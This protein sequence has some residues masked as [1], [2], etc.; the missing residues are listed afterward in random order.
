MIYN[1]EE[2]NVTS[3]LLDNEYKKLDNKN[4]LII[5]GFGFI[6]KYLLNTLIFIRDNL[7]IKINI[8][9]LDNFITSNKEQIEYFSKFNIK[10]IEHDIL[11]KFKSN[12]VFDYVAF[13]AGIAS[14]YYYNKFPMETLELSVIGLKNSFEINH[15]ENTKYIFF[16]SSEIYGDPDDKN[17][18]TKE[19][20]RGNVSTVGPRSCYDESK[21]L[22]ETICYIKSTK[23][24]FKTAIIRPFNVYGPG[25]LEDD[26]RIIPN[27][28]KCI[29]NNQSLDIYDTGI[30]T[31]TYCYIADAINGFIRVFLNEKNFSIYNIG[32][33]SE[34]INVLQLVKKFEE[35]T[36]IKI[37]YNLIP[38]PNFY[39]S[40]QPQRR[41]PDISAAKKDLNYYPKYTLEKGILALFNWYKE[42]I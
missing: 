18:P 2:L 41:K 4:I 36:K 25:M 12:V 29:K 8:T 9:V 27:I 1:P 6:G 7:N 10:C 33:D 26:Y 24:N 5:G 20:Y 42:Q 23:E 17:I 21:R 13:L 35:A 16:S 40:D 15:H 32:S 28:L 30:Q 34:E 11:L 3:K 22:G 38:Y 14:P 19:I 37:K 31:R 39:P